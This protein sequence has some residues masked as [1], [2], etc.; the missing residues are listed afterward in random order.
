MFQVA[1]ETFCLDDDETLLEVA[2]SLGSEALSAA[3]VRVI[4][5]DA[6]P[7]GKG[8]LAVSVYLTY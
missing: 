6:Q 4:E 7:I 2:L 8:T 1:C 3:A 5:A